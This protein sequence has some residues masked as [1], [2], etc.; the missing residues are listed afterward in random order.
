MTEATNMWLHAFARREEGS[1]GVGRGLER[2]EVRKGERGEEGEKRVRR[3]RRG[4]SGRGRT[5]SGEPVRVWVHRRCSK[6]NGAA[7]VRKRME[8][9]GLCKAR[10]RQEGRGTLRGVNTA[11]KCANF[12]AMAS[13]WMSVCPQA[14][15][16]T[17]PSSPTPAL[18]PLL[19]SPRVADVQTASAQP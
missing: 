13:M 11:R 16:P 4:E 19:P 14:P 5:R 2:K 9:H 10:N 7:N 6:G 12:R 15:A 18:P 3:E 8:G 17:P 1:W